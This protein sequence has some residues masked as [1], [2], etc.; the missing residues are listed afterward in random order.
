MAAG[1]VSSTLADSHTDVVLP[2]CIASSYLP[3]ASNACVADRAADA[4]TR[5]SPDSSAARMARSAASHEISD[6]P[7]LASVVA[8]RWC[9]QQEQGPAVPA[10]CGGARSLAL[11]LL[12]GLKKAGKSSNHLAEPTSLVVVPRL[13][14]EPSRRAGA[15]KLCFSLGPNNSRERR[16]GLINASR[17]AGTSSCC[18]SSSRSTGWPTNSP[19]G[20]RS[21]RASSASM[22]IRGGMRRPDSAFASQSGATTH[23]P[24]PRTCCV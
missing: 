4:N 12:R 17:T 13:F 3:L 24:G 14:Y 10:V 11:K 20:T 6:S 15:R 2:N 1:S 9:T 18:L 21:T 7:S 22:S 5:G 19:S 8:A 23:E 16:R